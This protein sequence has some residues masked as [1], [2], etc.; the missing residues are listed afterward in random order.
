MHDTFYLQTKAVT[1]NTFFSKST[2][3]K[4]KQFNCLSLFKRGSCSRQNQ[5]DKRGWEDILANV[6]T[7]PL[8]QATKDF[9]E[10]NSCIE[11]EHSLGSLRVMRQCLLVTS[12][13]CKTCGFENHVIGLQQATSWTPSYCLRGLNN[14]GWREV[15]SNT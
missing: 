5:S 13:T 7:K 3:K 9:Y 10:I 2:L 15:R 1:K 6:L 8:A 11:I 4:K 14:Q 12:W